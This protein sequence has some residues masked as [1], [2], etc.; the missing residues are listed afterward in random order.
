[1]TFKLLA[2]EFLRLEN[3]RDTL[4][5]GD[6]SLRGPARRPIAE[7]IRKACGRKSLGP[8]T[9]CGSERG[10]VDTR[11]PVEGG[12]GQV[13]AGNQ[14]G[15]AADLSDEGGVVVREETG[16]LEAAHERCDDG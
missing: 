10:R 11:E 1:M 2:P 15:D 8:P 16:W 4:K 3:C 7:A 14:S 6:D 9:E 13:L 12:L 5:L